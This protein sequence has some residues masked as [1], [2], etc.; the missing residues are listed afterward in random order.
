MSLKTSGNVIDP[1]CTHISSKTRL[2]FSIGRSF[3]EIVN[4]KD[5]QDSS[6]CNGCGLCEVL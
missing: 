2:A 6:L 1:Y 5:F 3:T 4:V